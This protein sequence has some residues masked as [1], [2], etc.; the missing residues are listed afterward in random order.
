MCIFKISE[1]L[2]ESIIH[3]KKYSGHIRLEEMFIIH[4][5]NEILLI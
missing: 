2:K 4:I 3:K 1:V 5:N